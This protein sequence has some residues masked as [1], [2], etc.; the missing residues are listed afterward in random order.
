MDLDLSQTDRRDIQV[1]RIL[2][3]FL[4]ARCAD[5]RIEEAGLLERHPDL[6]RELKQ[7]IAIIRR[8]R[9]T[10][11]LGAPDAWDL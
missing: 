7:P 4:D 1:G 8:L 10:A 5:T 3:E 11:R 6:A 2:S 9:R